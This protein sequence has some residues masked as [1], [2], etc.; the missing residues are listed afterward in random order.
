MTLSFDAGALPR[1]CPAEFRGRTLGP[2]GKSSTALLLEDGRRAS[3]L[4]LDTLVHEGLV[5]HP[6]DAVAEVASAQDE[7]LHQSC[8]SVLTEATLD[9][10]RC[11][12]G[13]IVDGLGAVAPGQSASYPQVVDEPRRRRL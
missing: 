2:A 5:S 12:R 10:G 3:C 1:R 6:R 9:L 7:R 8:H 11:P 4:R 13:V